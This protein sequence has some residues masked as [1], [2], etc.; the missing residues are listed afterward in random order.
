MGDNNNGF[1]CHRVLESVLDSIPHA[2]FLIGKNHEI[3]AANRAYQEQFAS[4]QVVVGRKCFEVSHHGSVP[5]FDIGEKCPMRSCATTKRPER[6]LH[7]HHGPNGSEHQDVTAYPVFGDDG[8]I[9]AYL[10]VVRCPAVARTTPS[11]N[12]LVGS[13]PAF[14]RMLELVQRVSPTETGVLLLGESGTGKELVA[15]AVHRLS[16]RSRKPFVP[17]DCSGLNAALFE[18]ELFGHERGAFTGAWA[19][20]IGL[21]DA[22]E[23]GTLFLDEIGDVPLEL[24]VKLLRLLE[25]WAYRRVGAIESLKA[26]FRLICAT[27]HDLKAM[28]EA[29]TFRRDL[30]FRIAT[31]PIRLPALRERLEDLPLLVDSLLLRI[32]GKTKRTIHDDALAVLYSYSFPGNIRELLNLLER[33]CLLSDGPE[34]RAEHLPSECFGNGRSE[35]IVPTGEEILP[36]RQIEARYLQWALARFSGDKATLANKLGLAERTFYRKVRK[37]REASFD[38]P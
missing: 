4:G 21:V 9:S 25:T 35:V 12:Q 27:H 36:L 5:C 8:K 10:E 13:A 20:K 31:Y 28:V 2:A 29:G 26:D 3:L 17:V 30:Y 38:A 16:A 14:N 33:A 6:A 18:S 11:A 32:N 19:R 1:E 24:Q 15:E 23:G 34:L 37:I 22:A 7:V